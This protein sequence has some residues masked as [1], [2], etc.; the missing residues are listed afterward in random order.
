[1]LP[2]TQGMICAF[3]WLCPQAGWRW[4]GGQPVAPSRAAPDKPQSSRLVGGRGLRPD[5]KSRRAVRQEVK[6]G[7]AP[8]P[9]TGLKHLAVCPSVC[10]GGGGPG[11]A[12]GPTVVYLAYTMRSISHL[13][14]CFL[15]KTYTVILNA[16]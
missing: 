5:Q 11:Q 3:G 10:S 4:P 12:V 15:L 2:E 1:M 8:Q 9:T 7:V 14:L 13:C 6:R 16:A